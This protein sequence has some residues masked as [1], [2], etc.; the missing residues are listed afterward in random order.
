MG[1]PNLDFQTL[2][3]AADAVP[4]EIVPRTVRRRWMPLLLG[5]V[6]AISALQYARLNVVTKLEE[7]AFGRDTQN[8]LAATDGR[9]VHCL[10]ARDS[11]KCVTSWEAAGQPATALWLGNSQLAAINRYQPG[12]ITG[13]TLLHQ[14]LAR[15]GHYLITYSQPNAN[16]LEH[17]VVLFSLAEQYSPRLLILPVFLDDIRE[18][19][20]RSWIADFLKAPGRMERLHASELWPL[21]AANLEANDQGAEQSQSLQRGQA[22]QL[23]RPHL[24]AVEQPRHAQWLRS[25]FAAP[26]AQLG[27]R[28]RRAHQAQG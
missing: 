17:A 11:Q 4:G 1:A 25:G 26:P 24:A 27:A 15:R 2:Q 22:Q 10:D 3:A 12:D 14:S 5:L 18:Q 13:S 8:V 9:I 19:G 28:H 21:V 20:I 16:L 7:E 6:I 23:A